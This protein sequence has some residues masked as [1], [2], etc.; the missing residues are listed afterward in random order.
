MKH[1]SK[2]SRLEM[3]NSSDGRSA[4]KMPGH[5]DAAVRT[6]LGHIMER[7]DDTFDYQQ[8]GDYL[9]ERAALFADLVESIEAIADDLPDRKWKD[10]LEAQ[11]DVL[12]N[13]A[14]VTSEEAMVAQAFAYARV[15]DPALFS[16]N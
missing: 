15:A 4:E 16:A 1:L 8:I 14:R 11:I 10:Q 13:F 2:K 7:P 9:M 12:A 6:A 3:N 5:V